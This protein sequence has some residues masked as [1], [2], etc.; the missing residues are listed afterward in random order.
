MLNALWFLI[1]GAIAGW[2]AGQLTKG[3]GFG[4]WT[5]II[6][7]IVG[8]YVGGFALSLLG[9]AAYGTIGQLI[10]SV[11]GAVIV[12]WVARM[13]IGDEARTRD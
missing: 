5:N 2:G 11:L 4:L 13:F 9:I 1:I 6:L 10:T 3:H 7:G 8:A 12:L